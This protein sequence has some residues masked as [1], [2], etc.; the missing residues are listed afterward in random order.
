MAKVK[1]VDPEE[2]LR[3][4]VEE[5]TEAEAAESVRPARASRVSPNDDL[6]AIADGLETQNRTRAVEKI[7]SHHAALRAELDRLCA[8]VG[9]QA[10]TIARLEAKLALVKEENP[11]NNKS[12]TETIDYT[13]P[14]N[15]RRVNDKLS[16]WE[17]KSYSGPERRKKQAQS[18][19]KGFLVG[20][21]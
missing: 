17:R 4:E 15:D 2:A 11:K 18:T 19:R 5:N 10:E 7:L 8:Q 12:K 6:D 9:S 21:T 14:E 1:A 16:F 3:R 13:K 20:R